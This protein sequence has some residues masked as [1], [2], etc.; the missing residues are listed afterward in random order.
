MFDSQTFREVN[1]DSV[2][3]GKRVLLFSIGH[4]ELENAIIFDEVEFPIEESFGD[5]ESGVTRESGDGQ[6]MSI[7]VFGRLLEFQLEVGALGVEE[8][9]QVPFINQVIIEELDFVEVLELTGSEVVLEL[10]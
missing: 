8:D 6:F 1:L 4:L 9:N 2:V 5:H 10:D 3:L 7:L